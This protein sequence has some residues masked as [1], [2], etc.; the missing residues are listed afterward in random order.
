MNAWKT[1]NQ[2]RTVPERMNSCNGTIEAS[3]RLIKTPSES[4]WDIGRQVQKLREMLKSQQVHGSTQESF[5]YVL[6]VSL[7]TY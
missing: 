2:F 5:C 3:S 7:G 4:E 1:W 6:I